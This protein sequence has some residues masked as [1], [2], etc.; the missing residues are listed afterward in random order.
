MKASMFQRQRPFKLIH[1][2]AAVVALLAVIV[3]LP[4]LRNGFVNFDDWSY[5][6]ENRCITSL[7]SSFISWAFTS[8]RAD[9]WHPLTLVSHAVDY[10]I[11]GLNPTGHHLTNILLH[12]LNSFL[13]TL[14]CWLLLNMAASA[15]DN[16]SESP[17]VSPQSRLAAAAIAGLLFAVHPIHV[18]SVA[19][20]SERKDVLCGLFF[21]LSLVA[22]LRRPVLAC[23]DVLHSK[24]GIWYSASLLFFCLALLSKPMA[25]TLPV[26]LMIID[27]Q[28][29]RRYRR[30]RIAAVIFEK[31]PFIL[32]SA[33]ASYTTVLAQGQ[34]IAPSFG[35]PYS[36]RIAVACSSV[37]RY[38]LNVV[39]PVGLG[40]FYPYP[41][42]VDPLSP[43]WLIPMLVVAAFTAAAILGVI[44]RKVW[45]AVWVCYLIML[46]P[47][48]GIIQVGS[49]AMADRY[50][51]LP[52]IPLFLLVAVYAIFFSQR[53]RD[54][55][56]YTWLRTAL[57]AGGA[58]IFFILIFL[59]VRQIGF[60]KDNNALWLRE[61]EIEPDAAIAYDGL[62]EDALSKGRLGEA[63]ELLSRAVN[64][65][66]LS[67]DNARA[68]EERRRLPKGVERATRNL[69]LA[70]MQLGRYPE[71]LQFLEDA[72][73]LNPPD[74]SMLNGMAICLMET[75][76]YDGATSF[77]LSAI[78][79]AEGNQ[80]SGAAYNTL[81]EL[82]YIQKDY[83]KARVA[84][85]KALFY[86]PKP[87]R[88]YNTAL[89]HEKLGRVEEAC[90]YLNRCMRATS[91][92]QET[93]RAARHILDLRCPSSSGN[94]NSSGN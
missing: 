59:T 53:A 86:E 87:V 22:Y 39:F 45:A 25:V 19:W 72:L 21:L 74:A 68:S 65:N 51:Y 3:Y 92:R 43:R 84:F 60:W 41:A 75:G 14:L 93:E 8:F 27:W 94:L 81:G 15:G 58:A 69:G 80:A 44:R 89:V 54:W 50:L 38:L 23:P 73:T 83:E 2:V 11:W 26:V 24:Q 82:Y 56:A 57:L 16:R 79:L 88:L 91:D 28:P 34:G 6:T 47:V 36:E 71:A 85:L 77:A 12:G 48:I 78:G 46:L 61:T 66:R 30:G 64:A 31:I 76:K 33:A 29:L 62:G 70:L 10:A 18:E 7:D 13:V 32:L 49:Q 17:L 42:S 37:L 63:V 67:G 52:S 5:I 4:T 20:A 1:L 9:N 55:N 40:P 35:I 90:D